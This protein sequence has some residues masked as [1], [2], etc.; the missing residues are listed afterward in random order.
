MNLRLR[1]LTHL[2]PSRFAIGLCAL[3]ILLIAAVVFYSSALSSVTANAQT[4]SSRTQAGEPGCCG[5][6]DEADKKPHLLA[7]SYYSVKDGM[8]AKLLLNNKGPKPIEVQ[9]TL[10]SMSGERFD[11]PAVIVEPNSHRMMEFGEWVANAGE[12][13]Q[14]GSI[15]VFHRG[16]DLVLGAQIYLVDE[17]RS[18]GF[19]EKMNEPANAASPKLEGVWWL[20][21]QRSGEV[22]LVLSN[23][24]DS[25]LSVTTSIDGDAPKRR[26]KHNLE[27]LPHET[28]V[29]DVQRDLLGNGRPGS[30]SKYG[31]IS[32]EHNGAKGAVVARA[33]AQDLS[34]GYS[35]A[36]Q[37]IDPKAAKSSDLQGAGLRLGEVGGETLAPVIVA[38]NASET[39]T[40]VSGR[41]PY[42]TADGSTHEGIIPDVHFAPGES[43]VLDLTKAVKASNLRENISA[44]G[45]EL[46]YTGEPGSIVTSAFSVSESGNQLFRV[47][48]W[49]IEAQRSATGGYPWYIEGDSST[50]VY[51]KNVT[52]AEQMFTL[53]YDFD[54]G[55]YMTGVRKVEPRQTIVLDVRRLRDEETPD[56]RGRKIPLDA[57]RGQIMWSVYG[58]EDLVLIGRSEQADLSKGISSNYACQ[59]CCG[60]SHYTGWVTPGGGLDIGIGGS[61]TSTAN[62]QEQN[63]Y[64]T[65]LTPFTPY[66]LT[67]ASNDTGILGASGD[68]AWGISEGSAN[69]SGTWSIYNRF[70]GGYPA[71]CNTITNSMSPGTSTNVAA[72]VYISSVTLSPTSVARASGT[73]TLSVQVAASTQVPSG[74]VVKVEAF[75]QSK[76]NENIRVDIMPTNGQNDAIVAGGTP[77]TVTFQVGTQSVNSTSGEVV[78]KAN[79]IQVTS[80]NSQVT[81]ATGPPQTNPAGAMATLGVQ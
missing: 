69:M 41:V 7:G 5:G 2:K 36:V 27:L 65:P 77:D 61:F 57:A 38:R 32:I 80:G 64:S 21:S 50:V 39:E 19:D 8:S 37:F 66:P 56:E 43:K 15:Q 26:V 6:E 52:D 30:M 79:I 13:F 68:Y 55:T 71:A 46:K 45:I 18:F 35:L 11:V 72:T 62:E 76:S 17:A 23:S 10:F 44:A 28:R 74:T 59:N 73:S 81:V 63:C 9:P 78:Y 48:L 42:T 20:P 75:V 1:A 31:G 60:N 16:K 70:Y 53:Q 4:E 49:D 24:S 33:M 3:A 12:Q 58:P 34:V 22:S 14:E 54:G 40:I 67:W 47:P 29:M 51:I 25:P